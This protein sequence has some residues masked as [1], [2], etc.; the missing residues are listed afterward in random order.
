MKKF[1]LIVTIIMT[2]LV[3]SL[4]GAQ[5]ALPGAGWK[6]GQ[7]IQ[8]VGSADATIVLTAYDVTGVD[9]PCQA[10]SVSAGGSFTY[11]TD[12]TVVCPGIPAGFQGSAV[13]SADQPIAA[14]VNVNNKGT[15]AAA[16]QYRGT[17]GSAV[18]TT[19]SFPLVKHNHSGRTTTFYVQNASNAENEVTATFIVA[20]MEYTNPTPYVVPAN[21]MAVLSPLDFGVPAGQGQVG[22][23]TVTG[24]QPLAGTSL[25][26]EHSAAV[27]QN[28]QASQAFT[29]NNYDSTVYCPLVRD[30][31][32]S[33]NQTTG[34]Q[35][36]NVTNAAQDITITYQVNGATRGPFTQNVAGGASHTFYTPDHFNPGELGSA[37]V[38]STG[39][40]VAVVNDKGI[41][42]SNPQR[43]TTYAC[44]PA[45]SATSTINLPLV[46]EFAGIN[47]T[48][49]QI[50]NVS[51]SSDANITLSYTT[52]NGDVVE[53]A[54]ASPVPAGASMTVY[55]ISNAPAN[56]TLVSG[57]ITLPQ[58][59]GTVNGVVITA[60]QPI[61]AIANE[62]SFTG[63]IQDT[64]NYE[65]FNK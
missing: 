32:T 12:D 26:H 61:V 60:D 6:S 65:G 28:L 2:M 62:S 23:L 7:Q 10:Q 5:T 13:A 24:T 9:Y 58:M 41:N 39:D 44:F 59:N 1:S 8:N 48:G 54:S 34:V 25:E 57:D 16:G 14:V 22:S 35:V 19:I 63:S 31:H 42:T 45:N 27:A 40:I 36:Q 49:I 38:T 17:D 47:T 46:K 56:I 52:Q 53:V 3:V 55:G 33:K 4:V 43:V 29:P 51:G 64:K 20:G 11:L 50:Q 21:S 15:G 37:T 30:G 18:A